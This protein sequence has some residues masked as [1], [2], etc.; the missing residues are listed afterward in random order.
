MSDRVVLRGL[1]VRAVVGV[2]AGRLKVAVTQAPEKGKAND[3][4]VRVLAEALELTRSQMELIA[5]STAPTKRLLIRGIERDELER[6][7]EAALNSSQ[8]R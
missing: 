7:I 2:H 5:G 6:R 8:K 4:I 3:A 1:S